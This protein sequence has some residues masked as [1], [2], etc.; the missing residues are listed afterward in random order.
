MNLLIYIKCNNGS[1]KL[2]KIRFCQHN[3]MRQIL[4]MEIKKTFDLMRQHILYKISSTNAIKYLKLLKIDKSS[5][6]IYSN[7]IVLQWY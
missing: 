3:Y 7:A 2:Q 5:S 1:E 6:S 4:I